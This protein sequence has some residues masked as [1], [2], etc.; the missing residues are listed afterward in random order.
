MSHTLV[1]VVFI[2]WNFPRVCRKIGSVFLPSFL[3]PLGK[4]QSPQ[5]VWTFFFRHTTDNRV[6]PPVTSMTNWGVFFTG[7]HQNN[8]AKSKVFHLPM[9]QTEGKNASHVVFRGKALTNKGGDGKMHCHQRKILFIVVESGTPRKFMATING[10][11]MFLFWK[12][13][14][15]EKC[16]R[17]LNL[18]GRALGD[19]LTWTFGLG[20][21]W[22]S[23]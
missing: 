9:H 17:M 22:T 16:W 3:L 8:E 2:W 5:N 20:Y 10:F 21:S 19:I 1:F 6:I 7:H 15:L 12:C 4:F 18:E 23:T 14:D 11:K 13:N